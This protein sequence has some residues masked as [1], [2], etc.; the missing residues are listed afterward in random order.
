MILGVKPPKIKI[1]FGWVTFLALD[2]Q[3]TLPSMIEP[4]HSRVIQVNRIVLAFAKI[5][6]TMYTRYD[7]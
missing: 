1:I 2:F 6:D 7:I 5:I 3:C 4:S